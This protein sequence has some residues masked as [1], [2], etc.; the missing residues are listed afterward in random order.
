M[1]EVGSLG[2]HGFWYLQRK[3]WRWWFLRTLYLLVAVA[4]GAILAYEHWLPSLTKHS[5]I[6]ESTLTQQTIVQQSSAPPKGPAQNDTLFTTYPSWSQDF[7]DYEIDHLDPTYW[8]VNVGPA[9]NSNHEAQYYTNS[10][11][12][13]RIEN[14][15]LVLEATKQ[16]EPGGYQYASSRIDTQGKESFLYGRLD[17]TAKLPTGVGT[18]P[19][20]WM[21]P[22]TTKYRDLSPATN[23]LRYKNGGEIDLIEAVG[24]NPNVE[25]GIAHTLADETHPDGTGSYNQI[26]VPGNDTA[27]NLYTLLW[28]P[29]SLTFA[30]NNKPFYVYNRQVGAD[31]KTWPFDQPFYLILNLALGGSWG[32]IDTAHFPGNGIDNSALPASLDVR[33][34]YYYPYIGQ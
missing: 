31:Y 23:A 9:Q 10:P 12:N 18:W 7:S 1:R 2:S 14:G 32:G 19:A 33:S 27:Y 34:I 5:P 11:A 20:V 26:T 29:D 25:Y 22:A 15:T 16:A 13:L 6:A 24:F 30:V 8:E 21:L 17:V 4:C 28:T 3:G